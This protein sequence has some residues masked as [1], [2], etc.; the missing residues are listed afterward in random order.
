LPDVATLTK[1]WTEKLLG[2]L[3]VRVRSKWRGG[4]W[5]DVSNGLLRFAVPNQWHLQ[6]CE[7]SR[8]DVQKVLA[9]HL[10]RG[11][12]VVLVD[13]SAG[14]ASA[15]TTSSPGGGGPGLHAVP[16]PPD[17]DPD[18]VLHPAEVADL[19][20]ANDVTVGGVDLLLSEFGGEIVQEE[21]RD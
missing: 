2:E 8:P 13:E 4:R 20:D 19:P 5:A 7:E 12:T 14:G 10:G 18:D 6:A 15:A 16:S 3:P 9:A 1:V 17:D 21:N 11:V